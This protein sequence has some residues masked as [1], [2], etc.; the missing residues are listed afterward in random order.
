[1]AVA[2]VWHKRCGLIMYAF[3]ANFILIVVVIRK[4]KFILP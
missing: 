1:M 2:E 4:D 3:I